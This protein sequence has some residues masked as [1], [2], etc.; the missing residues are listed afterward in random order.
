[1][2]AVRQKQ[3]HQIL[4]IPHNYSTAFTDVYDYYSNNTF[5]EDYDSTDIIFY[6]DDAGNK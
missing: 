5:S 3:I 2:E 1:M 4:L 6:K